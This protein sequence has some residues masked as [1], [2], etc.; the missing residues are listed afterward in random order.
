MTDE[1]ALVGDTL[2]AS[3]T[4]ADLPASVAWY[5]DVL[6]F[7]VDRRHEREG[8][9]F[10]ASL[11]AG[12][13]PILL[14]QDNGAKGVERAKGIGFSLQITTMQDADVL[15]ARVRSHGG[16]L[17][18]EPMTAPHGPRIFRLRDPDGFLFTISGTHAP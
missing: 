5:C 2:G 3:L 8:R 10:A 9:L 15:A 7:T 1:L 4:V 12:P 11:R 16:H 17:E 14:T 13:V 18:T 6:G